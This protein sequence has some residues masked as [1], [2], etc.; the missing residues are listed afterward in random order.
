MPNSAPAFIAA[1]APDSISPFYSL[2]PR[3][4][5]CLSKSQRKPAAAFNVHQQ[6]LRLQE[7]IIKATAFKAAVLLSMPLSPEVGVCFWHT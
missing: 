3:S 7:Q 5:S 4:Y 6:N 2:I 1:A